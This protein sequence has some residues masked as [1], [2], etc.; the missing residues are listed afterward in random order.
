MARNPL[1]KIDRTCNS[2]EDGIEAGLSERST[3]SGASRQSA[4]LGNH[5]RQVKGRLIAAVIT[6]V[7]N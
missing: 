3:I 5:L 2:T 4:H 7:P 1:L 6:V